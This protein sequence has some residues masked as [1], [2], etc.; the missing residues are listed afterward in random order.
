MIK[1]YNLDSSLVNYID[2]L[3]MGV[4]ARGAIGGTIYYVEGNAGN[5]KWDG[6]SIDRP[7]KTLAKAIA[8]SHANMAQRSRWAK[9]NTIYAF[10]DT[11]TEDLTA[12]PQKTDIVGCGSYNG[13]SKAGL[14][15]AH[16]IAT[17]A[18]FGCRIFNFK[19]INDGTDALWT[20]TGGSLDFIGNVFHA[21]ANCTHGLNWTS[22]ND[23]KIIGNEFLPDVD[24]DPFDTAAI[25]FAAGA[26]YN[27]MIRDNVIHGDIGINIA[28]DTYLHC[29]I[30]RNIVRSVTTCINDGANDW[31]ITNNQCVTAAANTTGVTAAVIGN[32]A[33]AANN[34][35]TMSNIT[36]RWPAEATI[37]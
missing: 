22:P 31:Y 35:L 2:N 3:G 13:E 17:A 6:L 27:C 20:I 8:V 14:M 4:E 30:D 32:A 11:F 36:N 37:D 10:G 19:F 28:D 5:D 26:T 16:T 15:G 18:A 33:L 9:R 1:K 7:L 23:V 21:S 34:V 12:V 24:D 29:H 25:A